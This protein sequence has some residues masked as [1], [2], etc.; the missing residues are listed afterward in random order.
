M[1]RFAWQPHEDAQLLYKRSLF[2]HTSSQELEIVH[3]FFHLPGFADD[4]S[5]ATHARS[6]KDAQHQSVRTLFCCHAVVEPIHRIQ[7]R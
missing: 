4:H 7:M 1:S 6:E 3:L 5:S 2:H